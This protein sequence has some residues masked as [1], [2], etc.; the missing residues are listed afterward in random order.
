MKFADVFVDLDPRQLHFR[1]YW[2]SIH[3][4]G[5]NDIGVLNRKA[6]KDAVPHLGR[7]VLNP[8]RSL[9]R[10]HGRVIRGHDND[11]G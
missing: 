9:N 3:G 4:L 1:P 6:K 5:S 7:T 2:G 10:F 8:H 11:S